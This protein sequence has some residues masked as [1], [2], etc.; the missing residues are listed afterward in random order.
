MDTWITNRR[1]PTA[2]RTVH[3]VAYALCKL[4]QTC[5]LLR[6]GL[7]CR[8][9]AKQ[10]QLER[11]SKYERDEWHDDRREIR[12]TVYIHTSAK[13]EMWGVVHCSQIVV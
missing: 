4:N 13:T 3:V 8:P 11:G 5:I 12:L 7:F 10:N 9:S 1:D 6:P 2:I